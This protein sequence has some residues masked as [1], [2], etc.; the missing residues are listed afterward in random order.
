[1]IRLFTA[2]RYCET[3]EQSCFPLGVPRLRSPNVIASGRPKQ[4]WEAAR[5]VSAPIREFFLPGYGSR[6]VTYPE[7]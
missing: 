2:P 1:M 4:Q 3:S 5:Q 6:L 7:S